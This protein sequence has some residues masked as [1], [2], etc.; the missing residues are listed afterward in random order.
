MI[1]QC[2]VHDF[3]YDAPQ[4]P[5]RRRDCDMKRVTE[6]AA[7]PSGF[8]KMVAHPNEGWLLRPNQCWLPAQ[9]P[10]MSPGIGFKQLLTFLSALARF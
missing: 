6:M 3:A 10:L 7:H 2:D 1:V 9:R 5:T 8:L 4:F